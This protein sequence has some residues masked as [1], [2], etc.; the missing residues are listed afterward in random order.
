MEWEILNANKFRWGRETYPTR[1]AAETELKTFWRGVHGVD[2]KKFS[3]RQVLTK[4]LSESG[5]VLSN[6]E[7]C[8]A[9][10]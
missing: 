8:D 2:L 10:R 7:Y 5:K 3:I 1:E 4:D 9:T 6:M